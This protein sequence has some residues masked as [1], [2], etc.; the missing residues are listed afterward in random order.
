MPAICRAFNLARGEELEVT[1]DDDDSPPVADVV[2]A[3]SHT[4]IIILCS[5]GVHLAF[6][7]QAYLEALNLWEAVEQDTDPPSLS[8]NPTLV[9]IKRQEEL[10]QRKPKALTCIH[11]A[12]IN[13]VFTR[14]INIKSPKEVWNK[15]KLEFEGNNKVK[16]VNLRTLKREFDLI[17]MKEG[18][19]IKEYASRILDEAN[20]I[21]FLGQDFPDENIIEK[22]FISLPTK[23][24]SK[25]SAI[26]ESV[27][28]KTLDISELI[29]RLYAF[30]KR[31]SI[32]DDEEDNVEGAFQ[33]RHKSK[34][35]KR[36]GKKPAK[37]GSD[38]GKG[39]QSFAN[40]DQKPSFPPCKHCTRTNHKEED[41]RCKGKP[42]IQCRFYKKVGHFERNC[43]LK[44]AQSKGGTTQ[45]ANVIEEEEE[46]EPEANVFL[47]SQ[48]LESDLHTW[49]V[50]SECTSHMAKEESLFQSLDKSVKLK[51]RIGNG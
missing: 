28:T 15:L 9:Q 5:N 17:K 24:E 50:D 41:C 12:V 31:L 39:V 11:Q 35:S 13:A 32:R 25:I 8:D 20:K 14:I 7:M 36:D 26:E 4:T 23:Y 2:D 44:N 16:S 10:I 18:E 48:L 49:L 38:K 27:D 51:I 30:E 47:A 40:S 3:Y 46:E 19:N 37:K 22:L 21:R 33:A 29:S 42:P 45:Q 6:K 43:R 1:D 34:H